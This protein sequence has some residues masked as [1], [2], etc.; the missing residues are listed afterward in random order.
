MRQSV[1]AFWKRS[2]GVTMSL[3]LGLLTAHLVSLV[4]GG[5]KGWLVG[6]FGTFVALWYGY[7]ASLYV[8]RLRFERAALHAKGLPKVTL[9]IDGSGFTVASGAGQ[10]SLPWRSVQ[11]VWCY[12]DF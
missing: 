1:W 3:I 7:L 2:V 10:A 5:N 11:D 8:L 9:K 6:V 4:R 12:P